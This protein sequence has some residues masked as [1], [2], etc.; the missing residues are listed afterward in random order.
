MMAMD[1][2]GPGDRQGKPGPA[3]SLRSGLL[4]GL[5]VEGDGHLV[6]DD[7]ATGLHLQVEVD[8]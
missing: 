4:D 5:D 2:A 7:G 1:N 6:A 3:L 8:A